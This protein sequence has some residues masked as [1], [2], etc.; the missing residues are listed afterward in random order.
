MLKLNKLTDYALLIICELKTDE[1]IT[2]KKISETTLIPLATTNKILKKLC[3]QKICF[4]K[5]GKT[6]GFGLLKPHAEINLLDIVQ[7]IEGDIPKIIE[8][9]T[10]NLCQLQK[11]CKIAHKMQAIDR[12]IYKVLS[13]KFISDILN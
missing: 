9:S 5:G 2:A 4:A 3:H 6:G 1:I 8:C 11:K 10:S 12:E 7:A 13:S